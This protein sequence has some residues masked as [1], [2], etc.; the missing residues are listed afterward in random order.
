[1][2]I[3]KKAKE[4]MEAIITEKLSRKFGDLTAVDALDLRIPQGEV[5]GL[6]GPN[7][8]GKTTTVRML[9]SI[10]VP[11]SGRAVIAGFDVVTE[12][13]VLDS[14]I[15][16]ISLNRDRALNEIEK[17]KHVAENST[18]ASSLLYE[19]I[20][21]V[22]GIK[23]NLT[24][25]IRQM[26]ETAT[27]FTNQIIVLTDELN[28]TT[29]VLDIYTSKD[30]I[31]IIRPVTLKR[32]PTHGD[33]S[34]FEF[35]T[36]GLIALILMF[37]MLFI[38]SASIVSERNNGTMAR[39]FLAPIPIPLFIVEKTL[40]LL[41]LAVIQLALM[42]ILCMILGV[43]ITISIALLGVMLVMALAFINLGMFIG[44]ISKTENTALLTSLVLGIPM[45]FLSGLFFPFEIMP[46]F[47]EAIGRNLPMTLSTI[48]LER[49][50]TY[51]T[52]IDYDAIMKLV[53]TSVVLF[54]LT[55][56]FIRL[57]PT[58]E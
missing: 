13:E 44:A 27:N 10:L 3:K 47:I 31:N 18:D 32:T 52:F 38:S 20:A 4:K 41:V 29:K 54:A 55:Y 58:A 2:D 40:Y 6:L 39:N 25:D 36:P 33:K 14:I 46:G 21:I 35:L 49:L 48:N 12:A 28:E 16:K 7:G 19:Q 9:N 37:I 42:T 45:L 23:D 26:G 50:I 57:K 1:V 43:S 8:A 17:I 22:E 30:P 5:F 56:I 24:R 51:S 15:E 11:T 34:Y 53:A